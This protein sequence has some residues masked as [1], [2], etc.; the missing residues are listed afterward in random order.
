VLKNFID[1]KTTKFGVRRQRRRFGFF[2]ICGI[3]ESKAASRCA[4]RRTPNTFFSSL[5]AFALTILN[6]QDH[7]NLGALKAL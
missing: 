6:G 1:G 5:L 4:C 2:N 7:K 3:C